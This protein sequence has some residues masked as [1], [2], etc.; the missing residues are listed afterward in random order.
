M[1]LATVYYLPVFRPRKN[2]YA[3]DDD[4]DERQTGKD[5]AAVSRQQ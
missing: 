3:D 4:D 1:D 5:V 2:I